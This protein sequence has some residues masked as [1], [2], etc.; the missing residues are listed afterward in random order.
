MSENSSNKRLALNTIILYIKLIVSDTITEASTT[1][2]T[3]IAITGIPF[4][5]VVILVRPSEP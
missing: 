1:V 2:G 5:F 4:S 3:P